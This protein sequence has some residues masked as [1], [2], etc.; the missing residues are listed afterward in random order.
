MNRERINQYIR[1]IIKDKYYIIIILI[2]VLLI[3]ATALAAHTEKQAIEKYY[4]DEMYKCGCIKPEPY[5][6]EYNIGERYETK[7]NNKDS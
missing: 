6:F 2:L 7:D 3:F 4:Q 1:T 5:K